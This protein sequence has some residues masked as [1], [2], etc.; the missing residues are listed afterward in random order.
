MWCTSTS[1]AARRL[2]RGMAGLTGMY[3]VRPALVPEDRARNGMRPGQL[4]PASRGN[5]G[6]QDSRQ[7]SS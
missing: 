3:F 2:L 5:A 7:K 1:E 6:C 4:T